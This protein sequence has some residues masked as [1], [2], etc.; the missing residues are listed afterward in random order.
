M[1]DE[2]IAPREYLNV[3]Q[4][5]ATAVPRTNRPVNAASRI[6]GACGATHCAVAVAR[7]TSLAMYAGDVALLTNML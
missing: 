1:P 5:P 7:S 6:M 4:M 3:A 2:K